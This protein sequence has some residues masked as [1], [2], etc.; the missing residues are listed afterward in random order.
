MFNIDALTL[1][2]L[3]AIIAVAAFLVHTCVTQG[4]SRC[5]CK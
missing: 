5:N 2:G 4:C 1:A 3:L